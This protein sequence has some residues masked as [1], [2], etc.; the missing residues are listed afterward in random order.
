MVNIRCLA[1][2]DPCVFLKSPYV[3]WLNYR[4][5]PCQMFLLGE[6]SPSS[7]SDFFGN[8]GRGMCVYRMPDPRQMF[9]GLFKAVY[10][11]IQWGVV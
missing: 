9:L 7:G 3:C 10:S 4:A 8:R 11:G 2:F 5:P 6:T 1:P